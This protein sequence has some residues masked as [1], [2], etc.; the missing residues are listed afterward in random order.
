MAQFHQPCFIEESGRREAQRAEPLPEGTELGG[1]ESQRS[2]P[3]LPLGC[4]WAAST[5]SILCLLKWVEGRFPEKVKIKKQNPL[6]HTVRH[7]L[8]SGFTLKL[9]FILQ[10]GW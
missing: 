10:S 1:L 8:L 7:L 4:S 2:D 9:R 3:E 5:G 6:K